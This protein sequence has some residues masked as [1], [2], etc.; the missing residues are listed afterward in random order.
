MERNVEKLTE[1][2]NAPEIEAGEAR[3][4]LRNLVEL[5]TAEPQAEGCGLDLVV[6]GRLALILHIANNRPDL[7]QGGRMFDLV[8]GARNSA[9]KQK[10]PE[11]A[12]YVRV[13]CGDRI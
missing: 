13:G 5:I 9:K 3:Q 7:R 1:A 2:P 11:G 4:E 8:A 10:A 6:H 12:D